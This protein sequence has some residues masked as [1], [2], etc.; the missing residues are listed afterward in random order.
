[1]AAFVGLAPG[2][3][4]NKP[5]RLSNWTQFARLYSD[6]SAPDNGPFMEGGYLAHAVYGFFQNGGSLCW[7]G[8]VGGPAG[9]PAGPQAALP[10]AADASIEAFRIVKRD[11]VS[12]DVSVEVTENAADAASDAPGAEKTEGSKD[13]PAS[14]RI[15]VTS[16]SQREEHDGLTVKKG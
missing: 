15:V 7:V 5:M 8:R 14:Y 1:V 9:E 2:G 3:P 4:V 11:G 13:G 16:G 12:A 6:P 10:A